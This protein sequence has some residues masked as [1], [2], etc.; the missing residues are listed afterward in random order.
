MEK[1]VELIDFSKNRNSFE[2]TKDVESVCLLG[3]P[4]DLSGAKIT[5]C[6]PTYKRADLLKRAVDSALA[7]NTN[8]P[9]KVYVIDND[10]SSEETDTFK[11][12]RTYSDPRLVYFRNKKNIGFENFNR[13]G[14]LTETEWFAYLQDD[15][16]LL[17]NY[18]K[19]AAKAISRIN[20]D[21][22]SFGLVRIGGPTNKAYS[23]IV[24]KILNLLSLAYWLKY[25]RITPVGNLMLHNVSNG[26]SGGSLFKRDTFMKSGGYDM[27]NFF[28]SADWIYSIFFCR[29]YRMVKVKRITAVYYWIEVTGTSSKYEVIEKTRLQITQILPSLAKQDSRCGAIFKLL[30]KDFQKIEAENSKFDRENPFGNRIKLSLF[31]KI[32]LIITQLVYRPVK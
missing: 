16:V 18:I 26:P 8:T 17:P 20:A 29:K 6:I 19:E 11:L 7:Q 28:P 21:A 12:M 9:Y 15:E 32:I 31:Y 5:I 24:R 1:S 4:K 14:L 13:C 25:H 27:K 23:G 22:F 10:D 30:R 3:N 2:N